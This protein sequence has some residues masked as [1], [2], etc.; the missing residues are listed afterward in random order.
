MNQIDC[1][2]RKKIVKLRMLTGFGLRNLNGGTAVC[3]HGR[4][5][6]PGKRPVWQGGWG[7]GKGMGVKEADLEA[8]HTA[9]LGWEG[10]DALDGWMATLAG[11]FSLLMRATGRK[12]SAQRR[13]R[14]ASAEETVLFC[15]NFP[16]IKISG[17]LYDSNWHALTLSRNQAQSISQPI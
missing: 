4:M 16:G 5:G 10:G 12:P 1:V 14:P 13:R 17:P 2:C 8:D 7:G 6:P 3:C 15:R 11:G 9:L